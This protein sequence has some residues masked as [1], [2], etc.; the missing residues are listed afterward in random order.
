MA[1]EAAGEALHRQCDAPDIGSAV[2]F[3]PD[4]NLSQS[5]LLKQCGVEE[6][7]DVRDA[8]LAQSQHLQLEGAISS[9]RPFHVQGQRWLVIRGGWHHDLVTRRFRRTMPLD[10][11]PNRYCPLV[12]ADERRH[13]P[14]RVLREQLND[15]LNVVV[16]KGGD[17]VSKQSLRMLV[18]KRLVRT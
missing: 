12:P 17:I 14:D 18:V 10:Q 3:L 7:A 8:L 5:E 4:H 9:I 1:A 13:L 16:L 11:V 15:P 2:V 6:A